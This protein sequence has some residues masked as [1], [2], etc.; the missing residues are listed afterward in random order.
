MIRHLPAEGELGTRAV[1]EGGVDLRGAFRDPLTRSLSEF[2]DEVVEFRLPIRNVRDDLFVLGVIDEDGRIV[3]VTGDVLDVDVVLYGVDPLV[4]HEITFE[5]VEEFLD[6]VFGEIAVV[7]G[8]QCGFGLDGDPVEFWGV[9]AHRS[10]RRVGRVV[11]AAT[12]ASVVT[13]ARIVAVVTV[14]S[15]QPLEPR[16]RPFPVHLLGR[17]VEPV[18]REQSHRLALDDGRTARVVVG[19]DGLVVGVL[20]RGSELF[21]EKRGQ[22][23]LDRREVGFDDVVLQFVLPVG[24]KDHDERVGLIDPVAVD[25]PEVALFRFG[26]CPF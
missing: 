12:A 20:D 4:A 5:P 24:V 11:H 9:R 21:G 6:L 1:G 25:F 18:P 7:L 3:P 23:G 14:A 13:V 2:H 22:V 19:D 17:R 26:D 15:E 8:E 16:E 10:G